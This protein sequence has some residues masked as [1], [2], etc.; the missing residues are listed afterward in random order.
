MNTKIIFLELFL[1]TLGTTSK[2]NS[3]NQVKE[4]VSVICNR[5]LIES[6]VPVPDSFDPNETHMTTQ[7]IKKHCPYIFFN[8]CSD[9]EFAYL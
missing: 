2:G 7:V 3:L 4:V 6:L 5:N 1:I 9:S 8:C